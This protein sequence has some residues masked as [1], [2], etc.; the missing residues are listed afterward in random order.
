MKPKVDMQLFL[1]SLYY[2]IRDKVTDLEI[3]FEKFCKHSRTSFNRN[4]LRKV[5]FYNSLTVNRKIM[6]RIFR[7]IINS[8]IVQY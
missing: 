8:T 5:T 7:W 6:E 3:I 4:I 2:I 1:D